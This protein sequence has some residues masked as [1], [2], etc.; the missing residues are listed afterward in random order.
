MG[1]RDISYHCPIWL[2]YDKADWGPKTFMVNSEW[3]FNSDFLPFVEKEWRI[4]RVEG[5]GD[6]VL[7]EKLT[8]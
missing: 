5:R 6:Y 8:S 7:K 4:L 2:I 1:E 3:F